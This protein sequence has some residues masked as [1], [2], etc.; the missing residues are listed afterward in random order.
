M[1]KMALYWQ[2]VNLHLESLYLVGPPCRGRL[3]S[4]W[5]SCPGCLQLARV[6]R[7]HSL[8]PV[9]GETEGLTSEGAEVH[10]SCFK[11]GQL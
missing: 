5:R 10:T 1:L 7:A 9:L 3:S 11:A 4:V 8:Q 6:E 2:E